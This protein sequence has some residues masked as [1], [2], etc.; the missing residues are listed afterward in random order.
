MKTVL[1]LVIIGFLI[2]PSPPKYYKIWQHIVCVNGDCCYANVDYFIIEKDGH[3]YF[4]NNRK[5]PNG[6]LPIALYKPT[7]STF[8]TFLDSQRIVIFK[9]KNIEIER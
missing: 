1:L 6:T 8:V 2:I 7:D 5:I 9:H 4:S 3:Y